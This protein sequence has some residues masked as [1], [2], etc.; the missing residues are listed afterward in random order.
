MF[1]AM[2]QMFLQAVQCGTC[3]P[4]RSARCDSLPLAMPASASLSEAQDQAFLLSYDAS[5]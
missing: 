3:S 1:F 2:V 4:G 5:P